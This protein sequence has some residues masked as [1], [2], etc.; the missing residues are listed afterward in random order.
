MAKVINHNGVSGGT[1]DGFTKYRFSGSPTDQFEHRGEVGEMRQMTVQVECVAEGYDAINDGVRHQTKWRVLNATLGE[2][3][4]RP[5]DPQLAF[6]GDGEDGEYGDYAD[7]P[8][9]EGP[10]ADDNVVAFSD[11]ANADA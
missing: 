8:E 3:I 7:A 9:P 6:D 11:H 1:A 10:A 4:E 2:T 5:E